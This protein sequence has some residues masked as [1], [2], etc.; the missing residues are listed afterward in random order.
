MRSSIRTI[1]FFA[2]L[3][4]FFSC[5]KDELVPANG[6]LK[7]IQLDDEYLGRN[8]FIQNDTLVAFCVGNENKLTQSAYGSVPSM[9]LKMNNA[10]EV[11]WKKELPNSLLGIWKSIQ[12][13]NGDFFIVASDTAVNSEEITFAIVDPQGVVKNEM[14]KDFQTDALSEFRS[15]LSVDC[16]ELSNGNI[17]VVATE[18]PSFTEVVS[19]HLLIFNAEL[20]QVNSRLYNADALI[21]DRQKLKFSMAENQDGSLT[22]LGRMLRRTDDPSL[23]FGFNLKVDLS[24][25]TPIHFFPLYNDGSNA[26]ISEAVSTQ[27]NHVVF[28]TSQPSATDSINTTPFTLRYVDQYYTGPELTLWKLAEDAKN[29]ETLKISGFP[30]NGFISKVKRT[31][32]GGFLLLGTCNINSDQAV[33]SNYK[34]LLIKLSPTLQTEW[35]I[36]PNTS[37]SFLGADVVEVNGMFAVFGS[38]LSFSE[39]FKPIIININQSGE[40]Q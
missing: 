33:P 30:K 19:P 23:H 17:A 25:L 9:M 6:M 29:A 32:D 10:G 8:I 15:Y 16:I 37:S 3:F 34:L 36:H 7:L 26:S 12:L 38:Y 1:L 35:L 21:L 14:Q 28:A 24:T 31:D 39:S 5:E 11:I 13:D 27:D 18:I 40:I 2:S 22:I 20:K 4:S